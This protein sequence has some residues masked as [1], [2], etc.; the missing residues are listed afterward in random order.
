MS[1][2]YH[3][4]CVYKRINKNKGFGVPLE[5]KGK[6]YAYSV[7]F[8]FTCD[9]THLHLLIDLDA[10]FLMFFKNNMMILLFKMVVTFLLQKDFHIN[11]FLIINEQN[12]AIKVK[13]RLN[14]IKYKYKCSPILSLET[15]YK[16]LPFCQNV[17]HFKPSM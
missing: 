4:V 2:E 14:K 13:F 10:T 12:I 8:S 15:F 1:S 3:Y 9:N 16:T 5:G 6:Y 7:L 17:T 11:I